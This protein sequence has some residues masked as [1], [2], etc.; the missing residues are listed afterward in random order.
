MTT[1]KDAPQTG[2]RRR[3]KLTTGRDPGDL[4]PTGRLPLQF[5]AYDGSTAGPDDA[6]SGWTC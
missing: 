2:L 6:T 1:F 5:T 4:S 3:R